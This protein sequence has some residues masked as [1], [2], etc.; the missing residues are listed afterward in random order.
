MRSG[1]N[2]GKGRQLPGWAAL[3]VTGV[4]LVSMAACGDAF[5]GRPTGPEP[6]TERTSVADTPGAAEDGQTPGATTD[7]AGQ[8]THEPATAPETGN[9]GS[10]DETEHKSM[11]NLKLSIN[12]TEIPVTWEDNESVAALAER[13]AEAP[14][15]IRMSMYGGFEQVGPLG[16]TLPRNDRQTTTSAG[17]IVL[18]SGSQLVVFYGSN[19]WAYMRLGHAELS[20]AD[21]AALLAHGDVTVRISAE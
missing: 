6:R 2:C 8:D 19:T 10:A 3:L 14:L 1:H 17:D 9:L 7:S 16:M 15:T 21:M 20:A 11:N 12:G 13:A 5:P 4:L 18:Y